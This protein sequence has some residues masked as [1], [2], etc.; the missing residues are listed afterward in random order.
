MPSARKLWPLAP[1]FVGYVSNCKTFFQICNGKCLQ[2]FYDIPGNRPRQ[3][4]STDKNCVGMWVAQCSHVDKVRVTCGK[5]HML[6]TK[7]LPDED[8]CKLDS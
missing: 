5:Y 2:C 3:Q 8:M 7:T 6:H 1:D 4:A